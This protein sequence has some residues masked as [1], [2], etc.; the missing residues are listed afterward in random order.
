[1]SFT[2]SVQVLVQVF[3]ACF[4]L[5]KKVFL[6]T[7]VALLWWWAVEDFTTLGTL[8]LKILKKSYHHSG[9]VMHQREYIQGVLAFFLVAQLPPKRGVLVHK[10]SLAS[11]QRC[12]HSVRARDS[13]KHSYYIVLKDRPLLT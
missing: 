7:I 12:R 4:F 6:C 10:N 11:C 1:V 5:N 13:T 3:P 9:L 2:S 8:D